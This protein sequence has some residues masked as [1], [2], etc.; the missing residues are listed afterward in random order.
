MNQY[1]RSLYRKPWVNQAKLI[2]TALKKMV[3]FFADDIQTIDRDI[4]V[5]EV[6]F[7]Q[8]KTAFQKYTGAD[9]INEKEMV[10]MV[11]STKKFK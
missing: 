9:N 5:W 1:Y 7:H 8:F 6:L 4:Q 10:E 3:F 11:R 2:S